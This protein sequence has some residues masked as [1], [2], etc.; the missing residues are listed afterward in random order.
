MRKNWIAGICVALLGS[1]SWGAGNIAAQTIQ[2]P[3]SSFGTN[4][5]S[6]LGGSI[7]PGSNMFSSPLPTPTFGN[8]SISSGSSSASGNF[9]GSSGGSGS[10][11]VSNGGTSM[12]SQ[13]ALNPFGGGG[14]TTGSIGG[15]TNGLGSR[16]TSR[17]SFGQF[18]GFNSMFGNQ[19]FQNGFGQNDKARLPTRL[20]IKFKHPSI[21]ISVVNG[22]IS[23]R[24]SKV[25]KFPNVTVIVEGRVAT[26]TGSVASEDDFE[27]VDRF[28]SLEPGVSEVDNQVVVL[29]PSQEQ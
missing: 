9:G 5:N 21:P 12:M 18:G 19:A 23:R 29:E 1:L 14:G 15:M 26:V 10:A 20:A 22:D 16:S 17:S 11:G 4:S 24:V 27:L 2:Q 8:G 13:N 3:S 28:V 25:A 6:N 7:T